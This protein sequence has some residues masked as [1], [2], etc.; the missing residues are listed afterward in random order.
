MNVEGVPAVRLRCAACRAG[1]SPSGSSHVC[2]NGHVVPEA[3]GIL[4]FRGELRGFDVEADR[5][6]AA[7]LDAMRGATLEEGLRHFWSRQ[8]GVAPGLVERFVHGDLI[9]EARATEVRDQIE[10]LAGVSLSPSSSVLEVGCGT[11]AL[12]TA[13][14]RRAGL[15]VVTDIS[16]A[17]LVLARRRLQASGLDHAVV[18][19]AA[20]DRLPFGDDTFDLVAGADVIEHV[21]D[22]DAVVRTC[23]RV[24]RP[25]GALWLSTPNRLSL[26]PEPHVR[27]WGVGFLPRSLGR[28]LVRR[29]RDVRYD[30]IRTLSLFELRRTLARGCGPARVDAPVISAAV[31]AGYGPAARRL[32]DAY[33]VCRRLPVV[34]G[35]L[36]LVTPLFHAVVVKEALG[37]T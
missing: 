14:A 9:G 37:A 23:C 7:E 11:A 1:I 17:W 34:R 26:T 3:F 25:G 18:I 35:G 27:V 31:R 24:L 15:V 36:L 32:I 21:P 30:D 2:G 5:R 20:A 4:D 10:H 22:A 28:R 19:A 29:L 6:L 13:L 33:H 8:P 16:L 12:G